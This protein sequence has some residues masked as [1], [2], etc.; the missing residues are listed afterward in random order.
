MRTNIV[1]CRPHCLIC[2]I[3][4]HWFQPVQRWGVLNVDLLLTAACVILPSTPALISCLT[5]FCAVPLFACIGYQI[6][7]RPHLPSPCTDSY[8]PLSQS[9]LPF[10]CF[11]TSSS[12][13]SRLKR[14]TLRPVWIPPSLPLIS[15]CLPFLSGFYLLTRG[16]GHKMIKEITEGLDVTV[17]I[18]FPYVGNYFQSNS[19]IM[20]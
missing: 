4:P 15:I 18:H 1:N 5:P 19:L 10:Q 8:E 7:R 14:W 6:E 12:S 2:C 17:R 20:Q 11:S 9:I 13:F 3:P 16:T